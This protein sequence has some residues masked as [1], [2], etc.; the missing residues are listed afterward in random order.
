MLATCYRCGGDF[1]PTGSQIQKKFW[2]CKECRRQSD[3]RNNQR[4]KAMGLS[5]SGSDT[6]D[7]EKK[8]KWW[9]EYYARP[10]VK[11]HRALKQRAYRENPEYR[12]K[13]RARRKVQTEVQ[14][15]R[16]LREACAECGRPDSQAHHEDY[17]QPLA[18]IWLCSK[19]HAAKHAKARGEES[20]E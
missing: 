16:I 10:D 5:I 15:G 14:A 2:L 11:D 4:R 6:W 13:D 20:N 19:C 18:V 8:R 9:R 17:A 3:A 7:P 12:E 1:E